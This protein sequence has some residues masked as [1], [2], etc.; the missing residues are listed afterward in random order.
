MRPTL[1]NFRSTKEKTPLSY[2]ARGSYDGRIISFHSPKG[3]PKKRTFAY[4]KRFIAY[5]T[6]AKRTGYRVGPGSYS[7]ELYRPK[8]RS[9]SP[10]REF[11]NQKNTANNGYYMVGNCMEFDPKLMLSSNKRIVK[12]TDLKLDSTYLSAR[13]TRSAVSTNQSVSIDRGPTHDVDVDAEMEYNNRMANTWKKKNH[14]KK[15]KPYS[16]TVRMQ[17]LIKR[18]FK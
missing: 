18:R 16:K 3:D 15:N 7:P 1:L 17:D 4:E 8:I 14:I 5:D 12:E 11:H 6:L 2:D 9:G 13:L 10:Y